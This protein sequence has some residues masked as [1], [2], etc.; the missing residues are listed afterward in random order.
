LKN[1][2][3]KKFYVNNRPIFPNAQNNPM[4]NTKMKENIAVTS[5]HFVKHIGL[6]E[7]RVMK[8][9]KVERPE[10]LADIEINETEIFTRGKSE[11]LVSDK[12]E[13]IF[14]SIFWW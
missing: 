6:P 13:A 8:V 4:P 7:N 14:C 12:Y 2:P 1:Q 3:A 5:H 9:E 10:I 11:F